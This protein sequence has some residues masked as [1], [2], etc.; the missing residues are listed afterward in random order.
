MLTCMRWVLVF[1]TVFAA[2]LLAGWVALVAWDRTHPPMLPGSW[3]APAAAAPAKP[4]A[5]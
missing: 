1:A 3:K 5:R 2:M 4:P